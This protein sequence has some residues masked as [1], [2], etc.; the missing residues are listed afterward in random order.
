MELKPKDLKLI[1][2]K[3]GLVGLLQ[4]DH[5][6]LNFAKAL[7]TVKYE[8]RIEQLQEELIK[9]QTWIA[10]NKRKVVIVFE[11]RDAAGKGGPRAVL[12]RTHLQW[13]RNA[14][15]QARA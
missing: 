2:T 6:K 4:S 14:G 3:K 8:N 7:R 13:P 15:H 9:L 1:E 10:E 12:C 11:G 5:G